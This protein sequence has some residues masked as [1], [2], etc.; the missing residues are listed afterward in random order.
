MNG[1][2]VQIMR[3]NQRQLEIRCV[4]KCPWKLYGSVINT[5]KTFAIKTLIP[6]HR[7]NREMKNRQ[8]TSTWIAQEYIQR[9]RRNPNCTVKDLE[10]DLLENFYVKVNV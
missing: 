5:E 7:C 9:F 6:E 1:H 8:A 4:E 10:E 2:N 3:S